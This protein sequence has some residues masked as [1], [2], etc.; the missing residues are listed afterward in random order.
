MSPVFAVKSVIVN[1]SLETKCKIII[2]TLQRL[3]LHWG[4]TILPAAAQYAAVTG[5]AR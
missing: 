5:D 1:N 4:S 3:I 2:R